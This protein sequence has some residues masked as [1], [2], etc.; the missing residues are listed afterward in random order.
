MF[1]GKTIFLDKNCSNL[2]KLKLTRW[3]FVTFVCSEKA[4]SFDF[5]MKP[6]KQNLIV[7]K[8]LKLIKKLQVLC[9]NWD[10]ELC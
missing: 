8:L 1:T 3:F 5:E 4:Q 10:L 7:A 2:K 6:S 9:V